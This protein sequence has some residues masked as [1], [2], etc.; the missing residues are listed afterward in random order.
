MIF[1]RRNLK[2]QK[3]LI[4]H[5]TEKGQS[6][7]EVVVAIALISLILI[8]IVSMASLSVTASTFSR[9]QTQASRFTQQAAEWLKSEKDTGWVYFKSHIATPNWCLDSLYWQKPGNCSSSD[10]ISG[11]IFLRS[12]TLT[13]QGDGSIK[14]DVKTTWKDGRGDHVSVTSDILTNWSNVAVVAY[15]PTPTPIPTPTPSPTPSITPSPTPSPIPPP[16]A[17]W[18]IDECSGNS[19]TDSVGPNT[20]TLTIGGAGSQTTIGACNTTGAWANGQFGKSGAS[21]N[22]DGTDDYIS[23]PP[24][25]QGPPDFNF[26]VNFSISLWFKTTA[27]AAATAP[28]IEKWAGGNAT[29][30]SYAVRMNNNSIADGKIFVGR[31]DGTHNPGISSTT[32]LNNNAWHHVV[33]T[34]TGSTLTLYIDGLSNNTTTDTTTTTTTNSSSLYFATRA[35][36][37]GK[38]YPGQIDDIRIYNYGLN[39]SQVQY[40]FNNPGAP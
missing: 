13:L 35:L 22:F 39:L 32:A 11:T 34:K 19:I 38:W 15:T 6:I 40:L 8:T 21:M 33:F 30:Y 37:A 36:L 2:N 27:S 26:N 18:K 10:F 1:N 24:G 17:W 23:I 16:V 5:K 4:L 29:P 7:F 28:L 31:S 12:V 9:N 20:G 25:S 3:T 14:V